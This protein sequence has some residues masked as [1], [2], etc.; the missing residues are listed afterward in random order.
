[1][2]IRLHI[3]SGLITPK[4]F[5]EATREGFKRSTGGNLAPIKDRM[6]QFIGIFREGIAKHDVYDLVYLPAKGVSVHKNGAL[7]TTAKGL[8]FKKALF[9]VWLCPKAV[10]PK[11]RRAMLGL[12]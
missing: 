10:I 6:E 3:V 2:A 9:G 1:M 5:E 7:K 8:E 11:L 4:N 12:N